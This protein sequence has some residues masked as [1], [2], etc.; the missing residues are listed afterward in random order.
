[1][2]SVPS[3]DQIGSKSR[4]ALLVN[5]WTFP[6]AMSMVATSMPAVPPVPGY[7]REHAIRP[8]TGPGNVAPAGA[9]TT[10][11]SPSTTAMP[12]IAARLRPPTVENPMPPPMFA[13]R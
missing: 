8:F 10:T 5:R 12:A 6:P 2:I 4:T 7:W 3:G 13:V 1:M 11:P 9:S